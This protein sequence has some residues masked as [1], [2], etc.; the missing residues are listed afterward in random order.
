MKTI[1]AACCCALLACV[2]LSLHAQQAGRV[3]L[4]EES[5]IVDASYFSQ[6]HSAAKSD[7]SWNNFA[8][9]NPSWSALWNPYTGSPHRAWGE[10]IPTP[11]VTAVRAENAEAAGWSFLRSNANLLRIRPAEL[12]L[13]QAEQVNGKW[14]YTFKQTYKNLEVLNTFVILRMM[15]DGR[16]FVFGS[17]FIPGIDAPAIPAISRAAAAEFAQAGLPYAPGAAKVEDGAL[18]ILP[19]RKESGVDSRLVYRFIVNVSD[20]EAWYTCV[21]AMGGE[22]LWRYNLVQNFAGGG[23]GGGEP[24]ISSVVT[25]QVIGNIVTKNFLA[26]SEM[27]P[28]PRVYV[29][30]NGKEIATDATG[31]FSADVG[32]ADSVKIVAR[33]AGPYAAAQRADTLQGARTAR[34]ALAFKRDQISGPITVRWD[35]ANSQAQERNAFYHID[36]IHAFIRSID[37]TFLL[38]D[39]DNQ[40][41]GLVNAGGSCNASW[42]GSRITFLTE[43]SQCPNTALLPDV[44]YHEYGHAINQFFYMRRRGQPMMNGTLNEA[45]ADINANMA[46]DDP[47]IGVGFLKGQGDG[48]IRN[49][50]NNYHYPEDLIGEIHDDGMILTGA[51][52]DARKAIGIDVARRLAQFCKYGTPDATNN[53]EAFADYFI[54]FMTADDNDGNFSNGTP[55]STDI[56]PAFVRHGI[57]ACGMVINH[58]P[59]KDQTGLTGAGY[60][61]SGSFSATGLDPAKL[62]AQGVDIVWSS[63]NWATKEQKSVAFTSKTRFDDSLPIHP[64]GSI[65]RYYLEAHDNFGGYQRKPARS[66]AYPYLFLVGY[67]TKVLDPMEQDDFWAVNPA[68][69]DSAL[70]GNWVR[71]VPVGNGVQPLAD[72]SP[73]ATDSICWVTGNAKRNIPEPANSVDSGK[74][75]LLTTAYDISAYHTPVLRYFRY[76]YNQLALGNGAGSGSFAVQVSSNNGTTWTD[77]ERTTEQNTD[78]VARVFKLRD[79][80][81]PTGAVRFR[82]I[83]ANPER[84][85]INSVGAAVDDFEL[86]DMNP[87]LGVPIAP[88]AGSFELSPNY[89]NPFGGAAG[90]ATRIGFSLPREGFVTIR[91]LNSLGAVVRTLFTGSADAGDHTIRFD[92]SGLPAGMY[93][94]EMTVAGQRLVRKMALMR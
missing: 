19:I 41:P 92:G 60:K 88:A 75:T 64:A 91:V 8:A 29:N 94:C 59:I 15:P 11:G 12:R 33:L 82:F 20:Q 40:I 34:L 28:L 80:V 45:T 13:T 6:P 27:V 84:S 22:V 37:T 1:A 65:V 32:T 7:N 43:N 77:L 46:T 61:F 57:P 47:R 69:G 42:N 44:V 9:R 85:T 24:R 4:P 73:A 38:R 30:V 86:L 51:V 93:I 56:I 49:S 36:A 54:E 39:L 23:A 35:S 66:P 2:P 67:Q 14:Y 58:N 5:R 89:P 3:A 78:W 50:N 26:G 18:C 55:H 10:G 87:A 21:D 70:H 52:W 16:V 48:T 83:A 74:T 17:D 31:N 90:S 76:F 25:G 79:Y 72:H 53:G 63:D 71:R 62:Y 81:N 68:P